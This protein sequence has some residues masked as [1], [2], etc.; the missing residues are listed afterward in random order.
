MNRSTIHPGLFIQALNYIAYIRNIPFSMKD[1]H[2]TTSP[3]VLMDYF[4]R[5]TLVRF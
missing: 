5:L 2:E 1:R 3:K 4:I